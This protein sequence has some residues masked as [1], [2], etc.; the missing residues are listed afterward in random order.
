M[1]FCCA[2]ERGSLRVLRRNHDDMLRCDG[3]DHWISN[4][5]RISEGMP[6]IGERLDG[7]AMNE[8]PQ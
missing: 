2:S 3:V 6:I 5:H 4:A 8:G 1:R 7:K